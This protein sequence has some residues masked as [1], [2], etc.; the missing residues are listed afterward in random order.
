MPWKRKGKCVYKK[1][2][3]S[4]K[5]GKKQGCSKTVSMA[6]KYLKALYA[7]EDEVLKE[8]KDYFS[9]KGED[10][11]EFDSHPLATISDL[12]DPMKPAPWDH[13]TNTEDDEDIDIDIKE[14]IKK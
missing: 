5:L 7:S 9:K 12:M 4:K 11:L 10:H 8:I 13:L 1:T 2:K 3:D 6:K 14:V